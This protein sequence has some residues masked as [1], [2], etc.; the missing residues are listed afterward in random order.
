M[1]LEQ[2]IHELAAAIRAQ[3][4]A[5]TGSDTVLTA[6]LEQ[7]AGQQASPQPE[8]DKPKRGRP[9]G[10]GKP[11]GQKVSAEFGPA[12]S[13]D[14]E[15]TTYWSDPVHNTIYK[16]V[17]GDGNVPIVGSGQITGAAFLEKQ[18]ALAKQ[19]PASAAPA[20]APAAA[21]STPT[22]TAAPAAAPTTAAGA[23][24]DYPAVRAALLQLAKDDPATGRDRVLAILAAVKV[25]AVPE[26]AT[27]GADA[28]AAVMLQIGAA[29]APANATDALFG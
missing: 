11:S 19:F 1:S 12:N 4:S 22:A 10:S 9:A 17:P 29:N 26:L 5:S 24:P 21:P 15:G 13:G 25:N 18:A 23:A 20:P 8:A 27:A 3:T 6:V 7:T 16:L 2:A 14:A 28:L